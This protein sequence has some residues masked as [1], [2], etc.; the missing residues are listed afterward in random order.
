MPSCF[1]PLGVQMLDL[2]LSNTR[3][4]SKLQGPE[5]KERFAPGGQDF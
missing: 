5:I 3:S 4:Q 2:F 1:P